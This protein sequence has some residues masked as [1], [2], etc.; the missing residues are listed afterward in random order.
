MDKIL[1][2]F[3]LL[4]VLFPKTYG[5]EAKMQIFNS[6]TTDTINRITLLST[7]A[8]IVGESLL[9]SAGMNIPGP[10]EWSTFKNMGFAVSDIIIG[11][12]LIYLSL[13]EPKMENSTAYYLLTSALLVSHGFREYEYLAGQNNAFC[14]N[15][16]LFVLNNVRL[17]GL[18]TSLGLSLSLM[19]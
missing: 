18:G 19:F 2:F 13:F 12:I 7:S 9:L 1:I 17:A 14:A 11:G 8:I 3:F 6:N 16:P 10:S 15:T 5:G 4:L